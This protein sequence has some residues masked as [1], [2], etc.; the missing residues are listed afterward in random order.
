MNIQ[1][2]HIMKK[3]GHSSKMMLAKL[4]VRRLKTSEDSVMS[5][6]N[7]TVTFPIFSLN[8]DQNSDSSFQS[9]PENWAA[10]SKR[11]M[12]RM[13]KWLLREKESK[14][15]SRLLWNVIVQRLRVIRCYFT[16]AARGHRLHS[17]KIF[18]QE[19]SLEKPFCFSFT[20]DVLWDLCSSG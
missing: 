1:K 5:S 20:K 15:V 16:A 7:R 13:K 18:F 14:S 11:G 2:Y 10:F 4:S 9:E 19:T 17:H 8:P 6:H 3:K 12:K